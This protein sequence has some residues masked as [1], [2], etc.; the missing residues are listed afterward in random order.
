MNNEYKWYEDPLAVMTTSGEVFTGEESKLLARLVYKRF[1]N[2]LP[3][4]VS[5]WR[6][7]L[8]NSCTEDDFK[9]LIS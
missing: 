2:N 4:S 7:I 6:R 1:G 9:K 3:L 5:V 8:Q